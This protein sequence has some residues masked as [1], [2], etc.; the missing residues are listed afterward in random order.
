MYF[1]SCILSVG[2]CHWVCPG[3]TGSADDDL[4]C[5]INH[6]Y[7]T[8]SPNGESSACMHGVHACMRVCSCVGVR[9]TGS[10]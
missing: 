7:N 5:V 6:L 10:F 8:S 4:N 9:G 1:T 3:V 2:V